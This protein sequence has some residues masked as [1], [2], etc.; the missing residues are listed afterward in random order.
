[1]SSI[2]EKLIREFAEAAARIVCDR[3]IQNLVAITTTLSGDD[4]GLEN[5]WEEICVQV[6]GEESFFWDTFAD[7]MHDAVLIALDSLPPRDLAALWLQ[8]DEGFDWQWDK[9]SEDEQGPP[10]DRNV[11]E[12]PIP[13]VREGIARHIVNN[14]LKPAAENFTNPN[15]ECY[16]EAGDPEEARKKLLI[17]CMPSDTLVTD[18]WD[19]DVRF[20]DESFEDFE[21]AAFCSDDELSIYASL[22]AGDF[23][24]WIDEFG[25][26]YDR[27]NH[28]SPEAFSAFILKECLRF[29]K[30]WRSNVKAKFGR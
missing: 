18:L 25:I 30:S 14:Y 4:S 5:A 17:A 9:D 20:E 6:Q 13:F 27:S 15:I 11:R 22:L 28:Q 1:M 21:A 3:A 23:E 8:S 7:T 10:G 29:M 12:E 2:Q 19:W 26:D 16:L 24:R